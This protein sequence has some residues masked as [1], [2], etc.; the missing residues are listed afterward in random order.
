MPRRPL[1]NQGEN[2]RARCR[3]RSSPR[4]QAV[5]FQSVCPLARNAIFSATTRTSLKGKHVDFLIVDAA[6]DFKPVMAIELDGRSYHS[7][8]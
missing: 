6:Q 7:E 5:R 2:P 8:K 1:W 3:A 4:P